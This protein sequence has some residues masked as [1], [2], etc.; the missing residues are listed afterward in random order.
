MTQK[1]RTEATAAT[2]GKNLTWFCTELQNQNYIIP[3]A[4][5]IIPYALKIFLDNGKILSIIK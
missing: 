4:L 1:N 3:Y 5:K 2:R